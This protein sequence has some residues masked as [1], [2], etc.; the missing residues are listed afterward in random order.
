VAEAS[1]L[2]A[3]GP[4]AVLVVGRSVSPDGMA[5]AAIAEGVGG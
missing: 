4:G 3:A 5:V 1:A 2:A